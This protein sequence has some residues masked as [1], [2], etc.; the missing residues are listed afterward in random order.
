MEVT[1][2]FKI[3][4]VLAASVAALTA[5]HRA[6]AGIGCQPRATEST[7]NPMPAGW[8]GEIVQVG[9][10]DFSCAVK[11]LTMSRVD[12]SHAAYYY[13][14]GYDGTTREKPNI[15]YYNP[16]HSSSRLLVFLAGREAATTGY[17]D[18]AMEAAKRGYHVIVLVDYNDKQGASPKTCRDFED[19][20]TQNACFW[21]LR[22]Y[23]AF[24]VPVAP[25]SWLYEE[26]RQS[27]ASNPFP[28][29]EYNNVEHRLTVLLQFLA[30]NF[31][32]QGWDRFLDGGDV[33]WSNI[34]LSG[35]SNG[36][37]VAAM[38]AENV[39]AARLI[40]FDGPDDYVG[41]S[42][43]LDDPSKGKIT[44]PGFTTLDLPG[45]TRSADAYGMT[46]QYAG[47]DL[48]M[49]GTPHNKHACGQQV[50]V[51]ATQTSVS[52]TNWIHMGLGAYGGW[53]DPDCGIAPPYK[54]THILRG[55][56]DLTHGF[57][58]DCDTMHSGT[59]SNCSN[60]TYLVAWDYLL[61]TP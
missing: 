19:A 8:D 45:G 41:T 7:P 47:D 21:G 10:L 60:R 12:P 17:T 16:S 23:Q 51:T 28:N 49:T 4:L 25:G 61:G 53:R 42:K 46:N 54:H 15:V 40:M 38:L 34:V 31:H 6:R 2:R 29:P 44:P 58:V 39:P 50:T 59:V 3:A 52:H 26:Y 36:A 37:G 30:G 33:A 24:G 18:F 55:T 57:G 20:S 9:M 5:S 35:H 11:P 48:G 32:D 27:G 1:M 43:L 22:A 14:T 13:E 56:L